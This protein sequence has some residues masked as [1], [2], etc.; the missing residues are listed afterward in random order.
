MKKLVILFI[1]LLLLLSVVSCGN[2]N[3]NTINSNSDISA[4][5]SLLN[6]TEK[7]TI[8][9]Q[10]NEGEMQLSGLYPEYLRGWNDEKDDN[11]VIYNYVGDELVVPHHIKNGSFESV[12]GLCVMLDGVMQDFYITDDATG[13]R[14]KTTTILDLKLEKNID[15]CFQIHFTPNIGKKGDV[16]E[17][18]V[19][20]F[21]DFDAFLTEEN[22]FAYYGN[23][24]DYRDVKCRRVN[25]LVDSTLEVSPKDI[26]TK[27]RK[28]DKR[29][30]DVYINLFDE[31]VVEGF[32]YTD[33]ESSD[34]GMSNIIK[35]KDSEANTY[36][37]DVVAPTGKYRVSIY[38]DHKLQKDINGIEYFDI[39]T[40]PGRMNNF[41]VTLPENELSGWHHMYILIREV[42]GEYDYS[43]TTTKI[44]TKILSFE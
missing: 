32:I 33:F 18:S 34:Y 8:E 23:S 22:E 27:T 25:M 1:C 14:S 38:I 30:T 36:N 29:I 44:G 5:E 9:D 11:N 24:H 15:K 20:T 13:E 12:I 10:V 37:I 4:I 17:L 7:L 42:N 21:W 2:R 6:E 3:E 40:V 16:L 28:A 43:K 35:A 19:G 26:D 41:E 31:D 39:E